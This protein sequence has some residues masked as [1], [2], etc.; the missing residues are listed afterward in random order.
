MLQFGAF[1]WKQGDKHIPDGNVS[2]VVCG[3]LFFKSEPVSR[4]K[5]SNL[6]H[7]VPGDLS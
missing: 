4:R 7:L 3:S 6:R 5:R 1:V 2:C